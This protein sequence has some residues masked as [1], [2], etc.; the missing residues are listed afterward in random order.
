[1]DCNGNEQT[2]RYLRKLIFLTF[3]PRRYGNFQESSAVPNDGHTDPGF[4]QHG[5]VYVRYG[6]LV[7]S[8][9]RHRHSLPVDFDPF[10]LAQV[11]F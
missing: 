5:F 7:A 6:E 3:V 10:V 1:M 8:L 2:Y 11:H 9:V 4:H